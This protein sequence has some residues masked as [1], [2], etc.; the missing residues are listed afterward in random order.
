M[1][2]AQSDRI[3]KVAAETKNWNFSS[4]LTFLD[5]SIDVILFV[6][7]ISYIQELMS[8]WILVIVMILN[9]TLYFY[10]D[11]IPLTNTNIAK[12]FQQ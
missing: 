9:K 2:I 10:C 5:I 1:N 3:C 12:L 6:S 8:T 7:N 4:H 11:I